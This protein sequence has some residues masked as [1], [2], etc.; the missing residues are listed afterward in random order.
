MNSCRFFTLLFL[1]LTCFGAFSQKKHLKFEH[2]DINAGLSQNNVLCILQDKRGFMWFGTRDGLNKYD[3]YNFT[4][5]K[6]DAKDSNSISNNFIYDILEDSKGVIWIATRG[7]GLNRYNAEKDMFIRYTHDPGDDNSLSSNLAICL[8]KDDNDNLWIGTEDGGLNYFEPSKNSFTRYTYDEH[9]KNSISN[10]Y[11][12]A[13]FTDHKQ[14]LW[15]GTYGAGLN[16]LQKG[17]DRFT[18]FE[19]TG[20]RVCVIFENSKHQLWLGTDGQGL[21]MLNRNTGKFTSYRYQYNNSNSIPADVIYALEED[22]EDNLWI[23]T[24]NGGLCIY[25]PEQQSF[26]RFVQD[27]INPKSLSNNSIY[28]TYKD[29]QGNMWVGTFSGGINLLSKNSSRFFHYFHTSDKNSLAQN[30]VWDIT[31]NAK[32]QIWIGTD[33]G[34]A[35]LFDPLTKKFKNFRHVKGNS[36]SLCGNYVLSICEDQHGNIWFGTWSDG[37]TVYNPETNT[38]RH[39]KSDGKPGSLSNNNAWVIFED[40]DKKIW[41]GTYGGGLNEFDPVTGL[42][43]QYAYDNAAGNNKIHSIAEDERGNL[44]LGTDGGG[45]QVFNKKTKTFTRYLHSNDPGSISDNR[46]NSVHAGRNGNLWIS[47]MTGLNYFDVQKQQFTKYTTAD[48]LPN[49][50]IFGTLEDEN[51]NLWISTNRGLSQFIIR[52][53]KFKNFSISEGLQSYEFKPHAFCKSKSGALYFGG[54]NGFN[55]FF[56]GQVVEDT[57]EPSLVFTGFEIFNKTVRIAKNENDPSPVK[58]HI[59][60]LQ[61]LVLPYHN[62]VISF[63]FASLNYTEPE[64]RLYAY[65]LEG[66]DKEW[67]EVGAKRTATYTNLDPGSYILQV[68][69]RNNEGEWSK[70]VIE[71]RVKILP[72]FWLTWWFR[73]GVVVLVAG[74]IFMIYRIRVKNINKQKEV[75][76]RQV[77]E[78]TKSLEQLTIKEKKARAEAEQANRAKSIFLATMS[79]EIRTPMN[80]VIGMSSLLAKTPLNNQQQEYV[81][82]I[83]VCGDNLLTVI[84]DILDFSKIESGKMELEKQ[85]FDLRTCIEEVL[86]V[87]A[88]KAAQSG[89]DLVYQVDYNVPLQ[90]TGD[91]LRLRQ[92]LM[93]LVSNAVKFTHKG[94]IFIGVHLHK[95]YEGNKLE[96]LFEVRDSGIGIPEDKIDHLFK[97]FS[98]VDSSTTRRYGGTGLGL[99]IC[100][101]LVNLMDGDI[102]V[103]SREGKGTT[104]TFSILTETGSRPMR[105]YVTCDMSEY[106]GKTILVVDDNATNRTILKNQLEHWDLVPVLASSGEEALTLLL[107]QKNTIDLVLTDMHM[108]GKDGVQLALEIRRQI[109]GLPIIL[110]SSVGDYYYKEHPELFSSVLTKPIKQHI[111]CKSILNSF[112]HN[113]DLRPEKIQ[114]NEKLSPV[115]A[116]QYPLEILVAEDNLINQKLIAHILELL[117]YKPDIAENGLQALEATRKKMYSVIMMDVQMPE[118]DGLEATRLIRQQSYEQPVIIALTANAM[119]GDEEECR[120]AGMNDYLSKPIKPE[121]LMNMLGKWFTHKKTG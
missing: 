65:K 58:K 80:G 112:T 53:N 90:I 99:A 69:S 14:N 24:E 73:V 31:E 76:E 107:K 56:P 66:F 78:R 82:T 17:Q 47:T 42:F 68:K 108:P 79:H 45:L 63:E 43:T 5:Y 39:I 86:D 23:G 110:L 13:L 18:R 88:N 22:E 89:L 6:N 72:P 118:M 32:G 55:E 95:R 44:W 101:K 85:P 98:Q 62:S 77:M 121:E 35:D 21:K 29:V 102:R 81:E 4:I 40:S 117:G 33:G 93:N 20:D 84:N 103:E 7:G 34:G 15:V 46:I 116:R 8:E 49:N 71:L 16:L 59:S 51:G 9:N 100:R 113:N 67:N 105:T 114:S 41:V 54:I 91:V 50:V 75:L 83:Q 87:F 120:Q 96:L 48:G 57:F 115:F 70:R 19:N 1:Q 94:E 30:N 37:I 106:E 25:N 97:A 111:L 104:F 26:Q 92:I 12:R 64:K 61:K 60:T 28:A 52:K 27:E 119:Q 3:G 109:P 11:V 38:Y 2:L 36:N 10:N 74:S